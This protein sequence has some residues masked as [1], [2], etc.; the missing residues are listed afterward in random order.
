[1]RKSQKLVFHQSKCICAIKRILSTTANVCILVFLHVFAYSMLLRRMLKFKRLA[2][3]SDDVSQYN[4][5]QKNVKIVTQC[6]EIFGGGQMPPWLRTWL[7]VFRST[8]F[9][10][11]LLDLFRTISL[12]LFSKSFF[13]LVSTRAPTITLRWC[14]SRKMLQPHAVSNVDRSA[15]FIMIALLDT[16]TQCHMWIETERKSF[17]QFDTRNCKENFSINTNLLGCFEKH[18]SCNL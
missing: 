9:A 2:C 16:T 7:L 10:I 4:T 17:F 5:I 11:S 1:M 6:F 8:S 13:N 14:T 18:F 12:R 3:G 15:S